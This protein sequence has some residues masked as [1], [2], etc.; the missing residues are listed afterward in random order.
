MEGAHGCGRLKTR[1]KAS[2]AVRA[3]KGIVAASEKILLG[4]GLAHLDIME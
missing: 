3:A 4:L 2:E 1:Y